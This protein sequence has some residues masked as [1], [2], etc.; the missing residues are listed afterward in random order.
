[1]VRM[2][3]TGYSG[4]QRDEAG[5]FAWPTWGR[6]DPEFAERIKDL[7]DFVIDSGH[8]IGPGGGWRSTDGQRKLFLSRFHPED[9]T[10]LSGDTY[11]PYTLVN[12]TE[13]GR[14]RVPVGTRVEY[15]EKDAGAA[16]AAPPGRSYHES[17]TPLGHCLAVDMVGDMKFMDAN[18]ARFGLLHFGNING[19][20]WHLQPIEL[21]QPRRRYVASTMHPL[22]DW[23]DQ[24]PPEPPTPV[25][26][27]VVVAKPTIR[28]AKPYMSGK[29]VATL[30]QI[31]KFWQWYSS[32]VDGWAGPKTIDGIKTMQRAL[33]ITADGVYGPQSAEAYKKFAEYMRS[34][35]KPTPQG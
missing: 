31:M 15:W 20:P 3:M 21:P 19:E 25:P 23:G 24:H 9:D 12:A 13:A 11:W 5:L 10:N 14:Y 34:L 16:P 26:H 4:A 8:P 22:K 17:T 29:E 1:M 35:N 6:F 2:Y 28:L 7:M 32:T 27:P 18:A 33:K 30:Q